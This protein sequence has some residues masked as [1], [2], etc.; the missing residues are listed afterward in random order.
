MP[1]LVGTKLNEELA[2]AIQELWRDEGIQECY[3][4][5]SEYQLSDSAE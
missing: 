3:E 1:G 4:R 2:T 5:S